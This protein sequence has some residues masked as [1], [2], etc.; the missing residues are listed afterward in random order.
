MEAKIGEE[1]PFHLP[2]LVDSYRYNQESANCFMELKLGGKLL[3]WYVYILV[4]GDGTLY[5]GVTTDLARRTAQHNAGR[6]AKYTA[7]RL[8]V[9]LAYSEHCPDRSLAQKREAALK[10][11][12]RREKLALLSD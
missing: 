5:T 2:A 6:G 7:A 9:R 3:E 11:L 8:P 12:S 1:T 10:R 4:C